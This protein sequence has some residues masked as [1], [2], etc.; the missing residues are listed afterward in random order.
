MVGYRIP[1]KLVT[2]IEE[3]ETFIQKKTREEID[4]VKFRAKRVAFGIYE[5][6]I[7]DTYMI[8]VRCPAGLITP[9]QMKIIAKVAKK[10]GSGRV[11]ITTRQEIQIHSIEDISK[12]PEILR[13]LYA[14]GLSTRGGGGNTVRNIVA[15]ADSG[16]NE[17]EVFDVTPYAISLTEI[18]IRHDNS[19]NL[20]RKFKINFSSYEADNGY[21]KIA[22]VGFI[23][24]QKEGAKGFEVYT[25]GGMG[26]KSAPAKKFLDFI[27]AEEVGYVAEAIKRL[28]FHHGNRKNRHKARL[29][30]LWEEIGGEKFK[31]LFDSY[32]EEVKKDDNFIIKPVEIENKAENIPIQSKS[33]QPQEKKDFEKWK[34]R[35]VFPQKQ[36][37]L[38]AIKYP[39][40]LGDIDSDLFEKTANFLSNY[41]ENVIRLTTMQDI[42]VRNIP[43]DA[44][45]QFYLFYKENFSTIPY[46]TTHTTVCAGADTCKLGLC[47]SRELAKEVLSRLENFKEKIK[48]TQFPI[49]R[50]SGCPNACGQH[51]L[52]DIGFY[53]FAAR[54]DDKLYPAYYVLAGHRNTP[55]GLYFA[56]KVGEISARDLPHFLAS[57]LEIYSRNLDNHENFTHFFENNKETIKNLLHRY[58]VPSFREDKNYYFD[59][60]SDTLF[61][62][63]ER[64]TGECSA[65][66]FDFIEKDL[67]KIREFR[68]KVETTE[69]KEELVLFIKELA[70]YSSRMLLITRGVE[71]ENFKDIVKAFITHFIES[72][73]IDEKFKNFLNIILTE[74]KSEVIQLKNEI[75]ELSEKV[76]KLYDAMDSNFQFHIESKN[77]ISSSQ[78]QEKILTETK[79]EKKE[80]KRIKDLRGVA[81]PMNFVKTKLELS[82]MKAG[83]ILEIYLDEGEPIQNVPGSVKEEGHE[84]V[85]V[86]KREGQYYSVLIRKK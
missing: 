69:N 60:G 12:V 3:L 8:R 20:P 29:R 27:L 56:Q 19:W 74:D 10:Y 71:A 22:D 61:S 40:L 54:K 68:E 15:P 24:K 21:A 86:E 31:T 43:Q 70:Y 45:P 79:E 77:K 23:A 16:I 63:V 51:W 59:W 75:I 38:Y 81:C 28:F 32:Y 18:M 67:E 17:K 37:D 62:L 52:G 78:M 6:R 53:G 76:K 55:E 47:L 48:D 36:K 42:L 2:E 13:E 73:Y 11:H 57:L 7:S 46:F 26:A 41:G 50:I 65:G 83:E 35:F 49:I 84:I 34:E 66:F 5:Q 64:S 72:G 30:F 25:A 58:T 39:L 1:E 14:A 33:L 44:L 9:S 80:R 85:S 82:L 4:P